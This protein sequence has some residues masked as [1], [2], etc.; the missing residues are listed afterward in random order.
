MKLKKFKNFINEAGLSRVWQQTNDKSVAYAIITAFRSERTLTQNRAENRKLTAELRKNGFGFIKLDGF[1]IENEGT[2]EE[3]EVE[4]E[5]FFI[6]APSNESGELKGLIRKMVKAYNQEAAVFRPADTKDGSAYLIKNNMGEE[7]IGKAT[8][9]KVGSIY[10]R[11][12]GRASKTFV[13]E[14]AVWSKLNWISALSER[15]ENDTV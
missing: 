11:M 13:F 1:W 12:R 7:Q 6:T 5:S 3:I 8:F 2:P 14:R 4:E 15:V 9:S 10:S